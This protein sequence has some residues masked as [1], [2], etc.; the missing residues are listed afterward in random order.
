[1]PRNGRDAC[2]NKAVKVAQAAWKVCKAAS[3]KSIEICVTGLFK[4]AVK[5]GVDWP[6]PTKPWKAVSKWL[7]LPKYAYCHWKSNRDWKS[8]RRTNNKHRDQTVVKCKAL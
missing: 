4:D 6:D 2:L 7:F 8:C 1:M 5:I 3:L